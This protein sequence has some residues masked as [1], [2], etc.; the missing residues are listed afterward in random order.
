MCTVDAY[1]AYDMDIP[2]YLTTALVR[3]SS[4]LVMLL[5]ASSCGMGVVG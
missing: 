4:V 3:G 5:T 2:S 1:I